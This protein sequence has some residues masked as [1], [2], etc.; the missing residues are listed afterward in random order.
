MFSGAPVSVY[1]YPS[2]VSWPEQH[3]QQDH[4][5]GYRQHVEQASDALDK[6]RGLFDSAPPWIA[7]SSCVRGEYLFQ[8]VCFS[9]S[10]SCFDAAMLN[11]FGAEIRYRSGERMERSMGLGWED[12]KICKLE[13]GDANLGGDLRRNSSSRKWREGMRGHITRNLTFRHMATH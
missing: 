9:F 1:C 11:M 3:Q 13:V 12:N 2:L 4:S 5:V 8:V 10:I 6:K 7:P